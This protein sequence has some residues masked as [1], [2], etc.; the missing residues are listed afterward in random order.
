M[1]AGAWPVMITMGLD[2]LA[3]WVAFKISYRSGR[4]IEKI[5]V[6]PHEVLVRKVS[7]AGKIREFKFNPFW[8]KFMV[9]RHEEYGINNMKLREKGREL[10]LG[11]FLNPNDK[12]S[13]ASAFNA[14]LADVRR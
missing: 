5:S 3:I 8:V 1:I 14:A 10:V 12:T 9:D 11:A 6:W 13:F 7:P 2:I 4:Q